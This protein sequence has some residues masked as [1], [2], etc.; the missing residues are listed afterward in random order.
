MT[1]TNSTQAISSLILNLKDWMSAFKESTIK[2]IE[3]SFVQI[4]DTLVQEQKQM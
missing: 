4:D 1:Q 2:S 3:K